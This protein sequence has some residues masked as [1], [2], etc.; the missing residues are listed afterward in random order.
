M[1]NSAAG[2]PISPKLDEWIREGF[3]KTPRT[4]RAVYDRLHEQGIIARQTSI[5]GPLL[6]AVRQGRMTRRKVSE[7]GKEVWV[8]RVAGA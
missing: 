4:L 3:F 1:D 7:E 5:S 6:K 2:N 8:Y